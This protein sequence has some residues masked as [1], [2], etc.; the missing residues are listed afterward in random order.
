MVHAAWIKR[1][2]IGGPPWWDESF[3]R[4]T[5]EDHVFWFW[6]LSVV[7]EVAYC[8]SSKVFY[9]TQTGVGRHDVADMG[10]HMRT[11]DRGIRSNLTLLA[12]SGVGPD[13]LHRR[14]LLNC[15]L[16]LLLEGSN[17]TELFR[18]LRQQAKHWRPPFL[19]TLR[20][21]DL[22]TAV[23]YLLPPAV[24]AGWHKKWRK[25]Q[26]RKGDQLA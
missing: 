2:A 12:R 7:G 1:D 22:S 8:A 17:D 15:Y 9:R 18:Y 14:A 5:F 6:V 10:E 26:S 20:R 21:R 4:F 24:L 23:S 25:H 13:Y 11:I 16:E 3:D 19:E